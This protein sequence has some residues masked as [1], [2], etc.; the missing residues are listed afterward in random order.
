MNVRR[1]ITRSTR[2]LAAVLGIGFAL[3]MSTNMALADD[4][5]DSSQ[6]T[7]QWWQWAFSIP[8]GQNPLVDQSGGNCM[9]GQRGSI[10]FLGTVVPV[11]PSTKAT[12]TCKVPEGTT[13]FFPVI[14]ALGYNSPNCQQDSKNISAR[15]LRTAV[16]GAINSVK[17]NDLD[18]DLDHKAI[19]HFDRVQSDVFAITMPADNISGNNTT[20]QR[21]AAGVYSPAVDDGYYLKLDPLKIG[22]HTL[23]IQSKSPVASFDVTYNL[24][25]VNVLE[26]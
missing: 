14:N 17:L 23:H 22:P 10:W 21:C 11:S 8:T 15:D 16:G 12:R 19:Y 24:S 20:I 18:V 3:C 5:V 13:L 4:H 1:M 26:K 6:L 2:C 9:V 7:A 25:V